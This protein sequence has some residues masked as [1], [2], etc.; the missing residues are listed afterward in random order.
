MRNIE[1]DKFPS[2]GNFQIGRNAETA[3]W[4]NEQQERMGRGAKLLMEAALSIG[5]VLIEVQKLCSYE[6]FQIWLEE[7]INIKKSTA[8]N[9]ISLFKYKKQ[10]SGAQS[11]TEAYK[12]I[13]TLEAQKK[14]DENAA[15]F[16]RAMEY[17]QTGVKP[18]GWRRGTDDR[19]AAE[20]AARDARVEAAKREALERKEGQAE[21]ER[22]RKTKSR[23]WEREFERDKAAIEQTARE[24]QKRD[25]FKEKIGLSAGGMADPFQDALIDYLEGLENDSRRIEACHNAIKVCKRIANELQAG[26]A[27]AG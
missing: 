20:E 22:E 16:R 25:E 23:E 7:N 19:L 2:V 26:M 3:E 11:L 10:I 1:L 21:K 5:E 4:I 6:A 15:A 14:R 24:F 18:E 8:Y 13:E 17:K 27:A 9:Y 12:L